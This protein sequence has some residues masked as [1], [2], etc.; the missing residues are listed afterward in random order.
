VPRG[1]LVPGPLLSAFMYG[2]FTLSGR[3]FQCRSITLLTG[4]CRA[5]N[6]AD[7]SQ[8]FGL[9]RFRSPLLAESF[10]FLRILRCFSS[11]GSLP[12]TMCSSQGTGLLASGFPHSDISGS[13]P[14]HGFPLLF[15]VCHV[16]LR[17]LTPRHPPFAF[18]RLACHAETALVL[19]CSIRNLS[20]IESSFAS[21]H[22]ALNRMDFLFIISD[23]QTTRFLLFCC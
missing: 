19:G 10:L 5:L 13:S 4:S 21:S 12:E 9:L 11:P 16:L 14:A 23:K 20:R 1:T 8:R 18:C 7:R 22:P 17:L 2:T 6:P 3:P 15:A